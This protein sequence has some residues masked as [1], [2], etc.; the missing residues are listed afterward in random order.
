MVPSKVLSQHKPKIVDGILAH[1]VT[2]GFLDEQEDRR[3]RYHGSWMGII[4]IS[5]STQGRFNSQH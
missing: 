2:S 5:F 4:M 1:D 3:A